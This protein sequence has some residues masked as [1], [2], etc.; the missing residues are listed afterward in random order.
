MINI[1]NV[2]IPEPWGTREAPLVPPRPTGARATLPAATARATTSYRGSIYTLYLTC[3]GDAGGLTL[4]SWILVRR[5]YRWPFTIT[6]IWEWSVCLPFF[7][8]IAWR[9]KVA[10]LK[11]S[12]DPKMLSTNFLRKHALSKIIDSS[13]DDVQASS[14]WL[15]QCVHYYQCFWTR[16]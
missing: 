8:K 11:P 5:V 12:P 9:P 1:V 13:I 10:G 3:A 16:R 2:T 4:Q 6:R 14:N 7:Y 15:N